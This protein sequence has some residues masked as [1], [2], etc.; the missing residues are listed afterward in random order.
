MPFFS[1]Q[2]TAQGP[3]LAAFVGVS[4]ARRA[5]LI[6]AGQVVPDIVRIRALVDTGA[7]GT[8]GET[9]NAIGF[10]SSNR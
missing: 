4:G 1:L 9:C 6:A 5:A 7:D 10:I 3:M 2:I 8:C